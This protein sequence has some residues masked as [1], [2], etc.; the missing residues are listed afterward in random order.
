MAYFG[1]NNTGTGNGGVEAGSIFG[2]LF[3]NDQ[4]AGNVDEVGLLFHS[5]YTGS[6]RLGVYAYNASTSQPG[7]LLRDC[8]EMVNPGIGWQSRTGFTPLAVTAN[9]QV[10][11]VAIP[12]TD[13][14]AY[15]NFDYTAGVGLLYYWPRSG[16]YGALPDPCPTVSGGEGNTLCIRANVSGATNVTPA[17]AILTGTGDQATPTISGAAL[18]VPAQ[19]DQLAEAVDPTLAT[20]RNLGVGNYRSTKVTMNW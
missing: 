7:A 15:I 17:P 9:Q 18:K 11:L 4:G 8:G 3:T 6:V 13:T 19:I 14:P 16:G 5:A 12:S 1:N 2:S 10:W 20:T